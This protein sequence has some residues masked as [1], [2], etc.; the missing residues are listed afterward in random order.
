MKAILYESTA[1]YY[2]LIKVTDLNSNQTKDKCTSAPNLRAALKS[3]F[4]LEYSLMMP[5]PAKTNSKFIKAMKRNKD[6]HFYFKKA[7]ALKSINFYGYDTTQLS[8]V[9]NKYK[10]QNIIDSVFRKKKINYNFEGERF[11]QTYLAHLLLRKGI[12]VE[13]GCLARNI[14]N[15]ELFSK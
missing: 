8:V 5:L 6:L 13:S 2:V 15:L 9:E 11:E 12:M 1:P 4:N 14:L 10:V 3:E 7:E